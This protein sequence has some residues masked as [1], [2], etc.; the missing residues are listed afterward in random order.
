MKT[1]KY[2]VLHNGDIVMINYGHSSCRSR[3]DGKKLSYVAGQN[4]ITNRD[5]NLMVIPIFR[6]E[7]RHSETKDIKI[8]KRDC[9]ELRR[10]QYLNPRNIQK[11]DRCRVESV[12]GFVNNQELRDEIT[13]ALIK[14]V[15]NHEDA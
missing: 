15:S 7:T 6:T 10:S 5:H 11:I 12:I 14:E 9:S 8:T 1:S 4:G 13:R 3:I 2:T